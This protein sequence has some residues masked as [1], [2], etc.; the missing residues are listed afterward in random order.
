VAEMTMTAQGVWLVGILLAL[1]YSGKA[2]AI[3]VE[4]A[5][6]RYQDREYRVDLDVVLNASADRVEA[7][8]RDYANY[9]KL[10]SNILEAKVLSR[11]DAATAMLYTKLRAC[12][13]LFC[14]TVKRV[15]RVQEGA[16]ELTALVIP[17]QSDVVAGRTHTV[18]QTIKGGTRVRYQTTVTPKFWVPSFIGRPLMLRTLREASIDMFR[19]VEARAKQ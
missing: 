15:E 17:E 19:H 13:G 4:K 8:L 18:L 2:R 3:E 7:V 9:P 12:S 10:D 1:G 5:E 11:P 6:T 16:F 14:R